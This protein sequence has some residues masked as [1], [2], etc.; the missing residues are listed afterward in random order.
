M[1][2]N[3]YT[4]IEEMF[5]YF[6]EFLPDVKSGRIASVIKYARVNDK[7]VKLHAQKQKKDTG[8]IW[9]FEITLT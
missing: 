2:L 9:N 6:I 7:E 8:F 5:S 3:Q 4:S 1:H